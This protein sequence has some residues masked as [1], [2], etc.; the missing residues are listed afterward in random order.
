[1]L[2][3][4]G[5]AQVLNDIAEFARGVDLTWAQ[6]PGCLDLHFA[7]HVPDLA[8][9]EPVIV[10]RRSSEKRSCVFFCGEAKVLVACVADHLQAESP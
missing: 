5:A 10:L 3:T 4:L 1:M 8:R 7:L 2:L 6:L 9:E